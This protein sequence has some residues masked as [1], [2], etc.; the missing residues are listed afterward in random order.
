MTPVRPSLPEYAHPPL[1]A[2][3]LGVQFDAPLELP[4]SVLA[5][6]QQQLGP[7]WI[8]TWTEISADTTDSCT[9]V[10]LIVAGSEL[11][12]VLADRVI[13]I[14][15]RHFAFT[16]LGTEDARYP[17]YENLRDGFVAAW[18]VWCAQRHSAADMAW[19]WSVSYLNRIHQGTVWQTPADWSFFRL[20]PGPAG[21]LTERV[22]SAHWNLSVPGLAETLAVD[23]TL[24]PQRESA[25]LACLWVRLTAEGAANPADLLDGMD[26]G[27]AA[28]VQTFS[29]LHSPAA[30][31]CWGLR[32]RE[33]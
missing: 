13:R 3:T 26:T 16:W 33:K 6:F 29:D 31:A 27:R 30:N 19:R 10:G 24:E 1:I 14:S 18:D 9:D 5:D 22:T 2:A 7:E 21:G 25:A 8:G 17:R 12:N 4:A 15:P 20:L 11:K 23:W 32:R 28:I